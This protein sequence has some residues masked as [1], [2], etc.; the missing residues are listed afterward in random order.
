MPAVERSEGNVFVVVPEGPTL[1]SK[2]GYTSLGVTGCQ[3][4]LCTSQCSA[5]PDVMSGFPSGPKALTNHAFSDSI[6]DHER[7]K[8]AAIT[9]CTDRPLSAGVV[10]LD[11][12]APCS[13]RAWHLENAPRI[14]AVF[15]G[16]S[17]SLSP[18]E[19]PV[20]AAT[21]AFFASCSEQALL[22]SEIKS[23]LHEFG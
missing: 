13:S 2:A 11:T 22:T 10:S 9:D 18:I 15:K 5:L 4:A 1:H 17:E 8:G 3:R 7:K 23:P 19:A 16:S 12:I 14:E 21:G 6:E 20:V